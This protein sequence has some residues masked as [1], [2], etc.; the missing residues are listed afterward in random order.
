MRWH[1]FYIRCFAIFAVIWEQQLHIPCLERNEYELQD[2]ETTNTAAEMGNWNSGKG[3]HILYHTITD[4][5]SLWNNNDNTFEFTLL[6]L[7]SHKSVAVLSFMHTTNKPH[8]ILLAIKLKKVCIC[9]LCLHKTRSIEEWKELHQSCL[10]LN[11]PSWL[12]LGL[13]HGRHFDMS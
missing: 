13:F 11:Q 12:C 1:K 4:L 2:C 7:I 5:P 9:G 10:K 6:N 3:L 8:L